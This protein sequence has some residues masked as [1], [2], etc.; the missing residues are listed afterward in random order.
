M[1]ATKRPSAAFTDGFQRSARRVRLPLLTSS[2]LSGLAFGAV[3]G[4]A[5]AAGLW[6]ARQGA[7]RPWALSLCVLGALVGIALRTRRRWSDGDVALYLDAK[8]GSGEAI[9]TAVE[10]SQQDGDSATRAVVLERAGAAL[11]EASTRSLRP[12]I[13]KKAH[14][15]LP[16]GAGVVVWLS[17]IALP[18]APPPPHTPPGSDI[19]RAPGLKG[20][21]PIIALEKLDPRDRLEKERLAKIAEDAKR[22][23]ADLKRGIEKREAQA[24]IAK[25]RDDIAAE[26]LR[27]TDG[28]NRPGLE[29]AIGKLEKAPGLQNAA[30]ALA[31]ADLTE[32]DR[33]MQ[34]LANLAEQQSRE[35]AKRAL[36]EAEKAARDKGARE[37]ADALKEQQKLFEER[38]ARA[39][40]LRELANALK[41]KLSQEALDDLKEFGNSGSPEAQKRL[42]DAMT[43]ALKHLTPEERERLLHN[44]QKKLEQNSGGMSPLTKEQL[45]DWAK[46]LGSPEGQRELEQMLR[47]LA[48]QDPSESA[49]REQALDDAERGGGDA[50]RGLG[51][52]PIP[53]PGDDGSGSNPGPSKN[54]GDGKDSSGGPGSHHDTGRGNHQGESQATD[55]KELRAKTNAHVNPAAPLHAPTLGRTEG[56]AGETARQKGLGSLGQAGPAEVGGV[57]G[58]EVP[59]EYR[60]QVG[61]YFQP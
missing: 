13:F 1:K 8:L 36:Q 38:A 18:P 4:A 44:L 26:R 28:K 57:E 22:L 50:A 61:R 15:L 17:L 45:E 32:F 30:K 34:K 51:A 40:A 35:Q 46:R 54:K 3:A 14:A 33:E 59:E 11:D 60:E 5:V 12:K 16:L 52:V 6:W 39:D 21:D 56:R 19:V 24:R 29:A 31:D 58:A 25:L 10:L 23:R 27:M 43:D 42:T 20:L 37:L 53:M 47:E 49:R 48:A 7:L 41:G 9:S 2:A 55:G